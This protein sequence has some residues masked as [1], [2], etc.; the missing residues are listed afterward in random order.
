MWSHFGQVCVNFL[1][2]KTLS[3]STLTLLTLVCFLSLEALHAAHQ[4]PHNAG[5]ETTAKNAPTPPLVPDG[6]VHLSGDCLVALAASC[7]GWLCAEPRLV[8]H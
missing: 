1:E 3:I 2:N 7:L 5:K 6:I 8:Q 4:S